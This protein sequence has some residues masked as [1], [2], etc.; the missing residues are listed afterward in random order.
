M[1]KEELLPNK[2]DVVSGR[3]SGANKH[4]GNHN[5]RKL[6][7][8]NKAYYLSLSKNLKMG[9]ARDIYDQ[10]AAMTPS[11]RFLQKNPETDTWFE[12]KKDRALEKISQALREKPHAKKLDH[13]HQNQ[14]QQQQFP[15]AMNNMMNGPGMNPQMGYPSQNQYNQTGMN[16]PQM[17]QMPPYQ[18]Q[19]GMHNMQQNGMPMQGM[20]PNMGMQNQGYPSQYG[21]FPNHMNGSNSMM[22]QANNMNNQN[23]MYSHMQHQQYASSQG[24]NHHHQGNFYPQSQQSMQSQG[25]GMPQNSPMQH[26][27]GGPNPMFNNNNMNNN[28]GF[29]NG[30]FPM[31][32]QNQ[33]GPPAPMPPP[34][35]QSPSSSSKM[36]SIPEVP[37]EYLGN[38][39]STSQQG[40][41]GHM[42]Q[43]SNM[44]QNQHYNNQNYQNNMMQQNNGMMN[45]QGY[46]PSHPQQFQHPNMMQNPN[47][48]NVAQPNSTSPRHSNAKQSGPQQV[49]P[50][51]K[52]D[53]L[54]KD[55]DSHDGSSSSSGKK[56]SRSDASDDDSDRN[57][58]NKRREVLRDDPSKPVMTINTNS[59][60]KTS[61][62]V[63]PQNADNEKGLDTLSTAAS[64]VSKS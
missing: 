55:V 26:Q 15:G 25:Y 32:S 39:N 31:K 58:S 42:N 45:H 28:Y 35:M 43:Q 61:T 48:P 20:N 47:M 52:H 64:L 53:A 29:G 17:N 18:Q 6:I 63:S 60:G 13:Q 40:F 2:N 27:Q 12:L 37:R 57:I 1:S 49:S 9:V 30:Q 62:L 22:P 21:G 7:K 36:P 8:D 46:Y 24:P 19:Q 50:D 16:H 5:F 56:R 59:E 3:G 11:G 14:N 44:Y 51:S 38:M 4:P 23:D 34:Q 41:R 54:S 33:Y 10:I